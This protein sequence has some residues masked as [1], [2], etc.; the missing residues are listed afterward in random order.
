MFFCD[1]LNVWQQFPEGDHPDFLGGRVVSIDGACDLSRRKVIDGDTGEITDAW[2]V[3]GSDDVEYSTAKFGQHR[4]S[5]ETTILIRMIGGRLEVRGNPSAYGRLD[6]LF[7]VSL[8]DGFAIYNQILESIGLPVFTQGEQ[9]DVWLQN[10]QKWAKEYTGAHVTRADFTV[11]QSVGMG[12]VRDYNKWIAGQKLSRSS[13]DDDA[14]EKF[15]RWNFSTVYTSSSKYWINSKHYDKAEALEELTLP[16]YL[17]KLRNA[18]KDGKIDK[19]EVRRLYLEAEDY[20]GKLAEWC[21]EVGVVRSEWSIRSRWFQQHKGA[22]WWKP[23]ETESELIDVVAAE[24]EKIAMRAIVY[25]AESYDNL[26]AAEYKALD[27][28]KKGCDVKGMIPKSS[29]YRI[30]SN[31]L[32]KTGHD[33]AARPN[34]QS[35]ASEFRPVYF[36]VRPLS[37]ADAPI[38]YQR[39]VFPLQ[40]AA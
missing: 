28:W 11:N 15:A 10:E 7:G 29:F 6:N 35:S 36:Q 39:P 17:K 27:Q 38:W 4:G 16:E 12:R 21:A 33:I 5:F 34:V 18:V 20:L 2:A 9:M 26:S 31:I 13:P 23:G 22:G 37:V 25:Q 24:K 1:W 3:C 30:R 40:L 32:E 19:Q 8:D 14:L